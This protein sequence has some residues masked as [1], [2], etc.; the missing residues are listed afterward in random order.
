M[1][2]TEN[3]TLNMEFA[4]GAVV[5]VEVTYPED[6]AIAAINALRQIG[7]DGYLIPLMAQ[8]RDKSIDEALGNAGLDI[9]A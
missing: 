5:S 7:A 8:L 6:Q 4:N 3:F 1:T 2:P 9:D